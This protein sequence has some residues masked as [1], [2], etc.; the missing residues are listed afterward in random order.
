MPGR[1]PGLPPGGSCTRPRR[2][3]VPSLRRH[4]PSSRAV[5]TLNGH[6]HYLGPWPEGCRKPPPESVDAYN[7]LVAEWLANGRRLP[8]PAPALTV[9][10]LILAF[11]RHAEQHYRRP[12]GT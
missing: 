2:P 1:L 9:N 8:S 3:S 4:S 10:E 11:W 12:D 7:A 5:V 6:D